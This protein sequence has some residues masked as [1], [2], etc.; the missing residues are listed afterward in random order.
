MPVAGVSGTL[1]TF[2][3]GGPLEG[4]LFGK[5]GTLTGVKGLV[6]FVDTLGGSIMRIVVLLEGD[7]VSQDET[8]RPIWEKF[9]AEAIGTFASGPSADS[10][11]P[12]PVIGPITP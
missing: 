9:L 1:S 7:G 10:L 3:I 11:S 8:F 2:F 4:R 6:G 5:T 12:L